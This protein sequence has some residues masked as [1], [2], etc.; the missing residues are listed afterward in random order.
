MRVRR[1]G[2][3][4][5]EALLRSFALLDLKARLGADNTRTK[6]DADLTRA[7]GRLYRLRGAC[8][9][10]CGP[11]RG[12]FTGDPRYVTGLS[13]ASLLYPRSVNAGWQWLKTDRLTQAIESPTRP[14]AWD[15]IL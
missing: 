9:S 2:G 10:G 13:I 4:E 14:N 12:G 6:R 8:S 1:L 15:A 3:I 7:F 11:S 5:L